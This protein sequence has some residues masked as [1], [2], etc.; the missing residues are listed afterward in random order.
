MSK[1]NWE[2]WGLDFFASLGRHIGTAGLTWLSL[3]VKEGRVQWRDLWIAILVGGIFPTVFT[4]LQSTPVP[5]E[6]PDPSV[7]PEPPKT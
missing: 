6:E 2:K 5:T 1:L 4:F 3:G 7:N